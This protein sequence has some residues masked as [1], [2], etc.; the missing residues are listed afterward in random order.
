M[1]ATSK[2]GCILTAAEY[3][4][5]KFKNFDYRSPESFKDFDDPLEAHPRE[6]SEVSSS[7]TAG[8]ASLGIIGCTHTPSHNHTPTQS[9]NKGL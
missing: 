9:N 1:F 7:K 2:D 8:A 4:S 6:A 3:L 5:S